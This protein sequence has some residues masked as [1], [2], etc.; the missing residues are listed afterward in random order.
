MASASPGLG[1]GGSIECRW[2]C[3]QRR[4]DRKQHSMRVSWHG[5]AD[6]LCA[7]TVCMMDESDGGQRR[8]NK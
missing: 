4:G 7:W 5:V 3:A 1:C 6:A 2:W 8:R